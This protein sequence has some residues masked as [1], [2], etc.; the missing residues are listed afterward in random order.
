MN[1]MRIIARLQAQGQSHEENLPNH[2]SHPH[3]RHQY[4]LRIRE[5]MHALGD[6]CAVSERR[7]GT[8]EIAEK[9]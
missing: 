8:T 7:V 9:Q 1:L 4:A 2:A 3:Q 6:G 5:I